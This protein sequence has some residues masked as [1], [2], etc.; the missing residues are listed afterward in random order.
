MKKKR[1]LYT[2]LSIIF[3]AGLIFNAVLS[4]QHWK[5]AAFDKIEISFQHPDNQALVVRL[6]VLPLIDAFLRAQPDSSALKT[7]TFLLETSL[8][9]LPYV[10][11][12]Q[13]YWNLNQS[14]VVNMVSK[15]AKAKVFMNDEPFLLTD[16]H[17]LLPA[18]RQTPLDLPIIT[19]VKDSANAARASLLLDEVIAS[20]AFTFDG[21][22]QMEVNA[23]YVVLIPQGYAHHITANIGNELA[24]DLRKLSAFYAAKPTQE[25]E[26]IKS[27]DLRY[28]NQVV[29]K[30]R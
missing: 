8:E 23:S 27:I 26:E 1:L 12:A 28:K 16:A 11:D 22:A 3:G 7:P 5:N 9:A 25:L 18:P 2:A 19:G 15:Q 30:T 14:L 13:V 29:S 24:G 4:M 21:L 17:E 10:A 6:E 20:P